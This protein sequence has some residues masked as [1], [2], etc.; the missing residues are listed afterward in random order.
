MFNFLHCGNVRE[1]PEKSWAGEEKVRGGGKW[2]KKVPMRECTKPAPEN[3][4]REE[5]EGRGLAGF[6]AVTEQKKAGG[7]QNICRRVH[8]GKKTLW[9]TRGIAK[10]LATKTR[11]RKKKRGSGGLK[12][13]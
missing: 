9:P 3:Q 4:T 1:D 8:I 12:E 10:N 6:S 13:S 2:R 11:R 7:K 5:K